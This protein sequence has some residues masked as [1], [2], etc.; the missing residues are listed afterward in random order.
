MDRLWTFSSL[1][2]AQFCTNNCPSWFLKVKLKGRKHCCELLCKTCPET[3]AIYKLLNSHAG[4]DIYRCMHLLRTLFAF[5]NWLN[6][7]LNA[8]RRLLK[9]GTYLAKLTSRKYLGPHK[10]SVCWSNCFLS[11]LF[12]ECGIELG[13]SRSEIQIA[14]NGAQ[15][16]VNK[17]LDG[18]T[19][20]G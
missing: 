8:K 7:S 10:V 14:T 3:A 12:Y 6:Y 4:G 11:C 13:T 1:L 9:F 19:Y 15:S 16:Y 2:V 17:M 20:H 5:T 18:S